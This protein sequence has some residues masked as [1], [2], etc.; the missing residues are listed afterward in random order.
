MRRRRYTRFPWVV[1]VHHSSS[2]L[3]SSLSPSPRLSAASSPVTRLACAS[4]ALRNFLRSLLL[5]LVQR[6]ALLLLRL[7]LLALPISSRAR[8][9]TPAALRR[10]LQNHALLPNAVEGVLGFAASPSLF[11]GT[12]C[13]SCPPRLSRAASILGLSGR[14]RACARLPLLDCWPIAEKG[15][16]RAGGGRQPPP[17][18]KTLS[19]NAESS[20]S[21]AS[22]VREV[23]GYLDDRLRSRA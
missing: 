5:P 20:K 17:P 2:S 18:P 21:R 13:S 15:D 16:T 7:E 11:S 19:G 8:Y 10:R 23:L 22:L 3:V 4:S 12:S 6:R 14:H 1:H 9:R